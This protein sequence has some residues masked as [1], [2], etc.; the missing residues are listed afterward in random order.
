MGEGVLDMISHNFTPKKIA[1]FRKFFQK[2]FTVM[3]EIRFAPKHLQMT[4]CQEGRRKYKQV[5]TKDKTRS[6]NWSI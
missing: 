3:T 6:K 4:I 5:R 2:F 1:N